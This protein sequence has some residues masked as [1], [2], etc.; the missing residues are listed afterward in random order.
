[1][2]A[3]SASISAQMGSTP[4]CSLRDPLHDFKIGV[5]FDTALEILFAHIGSV[6]DGLVGQQGHGRKD[7]RLFLAAFHRTGGLAFIQA[8]LTRFKKSSSAW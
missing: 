8:S 7:F 2:P 5:I 4:A 1:M 3:I 6:N